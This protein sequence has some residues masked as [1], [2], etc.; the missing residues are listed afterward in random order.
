M[1]S[2]NLKRNEVIEIL[3]PD[4][5]VNKYGL[6]INQK[7]I[8][9]GAKWTKKY[10]SFRVGDLFKA[11]KL[12]TECIGL[13][14]HNTTDLINVYDDAEQYTRATYPNQNMGD[15]RV[16]FY[17]DDVAAWQNLELNEIGWHSSTGGNGQGNINTIAIESIM[18]GSG[19]DEDLGAY[20]NTAKL[21]AI[22]LYDNKWTIKN[23]YTHNHWLG[24]GDYIVKGAKKN[25]PLYILQQNNGWEKFL[26]R[27]QNY[28]DMIIKENDKSTSFYRVQVGAFNS[29]E[30]ANRL[31]LDLIDKGYSPIIKQ[32]T[33]VIDTSLITKQIKDV[34]EKEYQEKVNKFNELKSTL[35]K[36]I[37]ESEV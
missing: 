15:A 37:N 30:N 21:T 6:T 17:V 8:P 14:I 31:V 26:N 1:G 4:K 18:D 36:V 7:I 16:H 22:L 19:S 33:D 29:K 20:E 34:L 32:D 3:K 11:D 28:L 2:R 12:M 35:I 9:F 13:T 24:Q 25:C 5:V 23:V 10:G 27:V